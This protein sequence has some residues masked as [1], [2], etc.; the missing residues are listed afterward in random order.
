M[1]DLSDCVKR[2]EDWNNGKDLILCGEGGNFCSGGDLTFVT[3][4]LHLGREMS[5]FMHDTTTRLHNLP[6]ISV[7]LIQGKSCKNWQ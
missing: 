3:K 7:A 5:T 2:L 6:L 1:V 4:A